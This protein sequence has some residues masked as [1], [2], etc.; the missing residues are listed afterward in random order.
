MRSK[1]WLYTLISVGILF[2]AIACFWP[3][4]LNADEQASLFFS[5]ISIGESLTR[6]NS[7]P[8]YPFLLRIWLWLLPGEL[9]PELLYRL[10]SLIFSSISVFFAWRI[11]RSHIF[12]F[13]W[14]INPA[15]ISFA[16]DVKNS[17]LFELT[18]LCFV[19][20]SLQKPQVRNDFHQQLKILIGSIFVL[21]SHYLGGI[22]IFSYFG[23][24]TLKKI[25][26]PFSRKL[27]IAAAL[28]ASA[29]LVFLNYSIVHTNSLGWMRSFHGGDL[30]MLIYQPIWVLGSYSWS[31]TLTH[32]FLATYVTTRSRAT[33]AWW[34]FLLIGV[35]I[36]S[37]LATDQSIG[38]SRFLIPAQ[39][40]L[41]HASAQGLILL[42]RRG[43]L[44][45][46]LFFAVCTLIS[47][48]S[49]KKIVED[50]IVTK[51]VWKELAIDFCTTRTPQRHHY[52][53]G[54]Q[55]ID[56]YFNKNCAIRVYE[57]SA[58]NR[59]PS[60]WILQKQ[61]LPSLE[62]LIRSCFK[63]ASLLRI[64]EKGSDSYEPILIYEV[65]HSE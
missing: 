10:P 48:L 35:Y 30:L 15:S 29:G 55:S 59:N 44:G 46:R 9:L 62:R 61:S 64:D 25:V 38:F 65:R 37:S 24:G 4:S 42:Q 3:Q 14:T 11:F 18:T 41:I 23:L 12:L 52:L 2:R 36:C 60:Y 6:D 17:A 40:L 47:T 26:T 31:L 32:L 19:G 5:T 58:I 13:L 39:V 22:L 51:A 54:H 8:L 33:S 20:L 49:L 28:A 1:V 34:F 56:F 57:C 27:T 63:N 53:L 50:R 43:L 16:C 45:Q 7:A 21:G